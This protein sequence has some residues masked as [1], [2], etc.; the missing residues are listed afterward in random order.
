MNKV[1]LLYIEDSDRLLGAF[2]TLEKA[3]DHADVTEPWGQEGQSWYA[4]NVRNLVPNYRAVTHYRIDM[5]FLDP[6]R[7]LRERR[8]PID[9][10][11]AIAQSD[12]HRLR[13]GR[14]GLH[15]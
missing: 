12:A 9:I 13:S 7:F 5:M 4:Q 11:Q 10:E 14:G 8:E 6:E 1:Y 15:G 2:T 3:M